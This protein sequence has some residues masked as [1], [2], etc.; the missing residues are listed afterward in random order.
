MEEEYTLDLR[1]LWKIIRKRLKLILGIT[2][3]CVVVTGILS[4]FVIPPTYEAST[5]IIIGKA[6]DEHSTTSQSNDNDIYMYQKLIKTYASI[7]QSNLVADET[8]QKLNNDMA[9]KDIQKAMTVTPEIDTQILDIKSQSKDPVLAQKITNTLAE[10][11]IT[12][13]QKIYPSDNIKVMD[14]AKL[15]DKPVKPRK[16]LNLAIAFFI[17]LMGSAGLAFMIEY[18][19]NTIKTEND[20]DK[21]LQLPVLGVIPK[22]LEDAS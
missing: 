15:P 1:E 13:S 8:A 20:V 12:E 14:A 6:P 4:F 10:T 16:T 11:F 9:G 5:S 3:F 2:A 7:A 17:G 18:M 19:D 21:F 22:N